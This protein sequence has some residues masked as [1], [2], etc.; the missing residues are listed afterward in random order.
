MVG[1][2]RQELYAIDLPPFSS[3]STDVSALP[4]CLSLVAQKKHPTH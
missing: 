3:F 4:L 2:L 1:A